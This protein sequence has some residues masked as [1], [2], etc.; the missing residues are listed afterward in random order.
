M[1]SFEFVFFQC[2]K[3]VAEV[4][5]IPWKC[6]Y[7]RIGPRAQFCIIL[8]AP[9]NFKIESFKIVRV[10]LCTNSFFY[11]SFSNEQ[12]HFHTANLVLQIILVYNPF[13]YLISILIVFSFFS[14]KNIFHF[15]LL[16]NI[17]RNISFV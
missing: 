17:V 3:L 7:F 2:I 5:W 10:L 8:L 1:I 4:G 14:A 12:S 15:C 9:F 11:V 16:L 6:S 13:V